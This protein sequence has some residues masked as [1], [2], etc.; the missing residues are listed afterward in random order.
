MS[1][2]IH[3]QTDSLTSF[4]SEESSAKSRIATAQSAKPP[5]PI[6][7]ETIPSAPVD[8]ACIYRVEQLLDA[9]EMAIALA[10]AEELTR[11][12]PPAARARSK[13]TKPVLD[14]KLTVAMPVYNEERTL[15]EIVERVRAVPLDMEI[16]IVDDCSTD[17]THEILKE[18]EKLP[19]VRVLYHQFNHG[20]GAALRTAFLYAQGDVVIVQDADLE[21]DP[22]D[23]IELVRPIVE[24]KTDVVYGS[25]FLGEAIRDPS[26]VHRLGNRVLTGL[27]NML[28]GQRLTDMETCYKV[29]RRE[30]LAEIDIKQDRF[31]FEPEITAKL[32]RRK[33]RILELPIRYNGRSYEEGKKIGLRDAFNALYCIVRYQW[34]D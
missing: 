26:F 5:M 28:T 23:Y 17:G 29:F 4:D 20:K 19:E 22:S 27:S 2:S 32:A 15:R 3:S 21:Y 12:K 33:Q 11:P 18:L 24:G 1:N 34:A 10:A 16:V 8:E 30:V 31:G 14:C 25:R 7:P 13:R 6:L 9:T